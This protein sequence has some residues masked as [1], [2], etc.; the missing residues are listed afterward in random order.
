MRKRV[1]SLL[2]AICLVV[3]LL[4]PTVILAEPAAATESVTIK[5]N[6]AAISVTVEPGNVYYAKAANGTPYDSGFGLNTPGDGSWTMKLDNTKAPAE[7]TLKNGGILLNN[8]LALEISGN[9]ALKIIVEG[10][11]K[12]Q[13]KNRQTT[14]FAM[15]GGTTITSVDNS[16]L[17]FVNTGTSAY[18]A[19]GVSAGSL[20]LDNANVYASNNAHATNSTIMSAIYAKDL[21]VTVKGGNLEV[22]SKN[23]GAL[24]ITAGNL[25][26]QDNAVVTATSTGGSLSNV[27]VEAHQNA[28]VGIR[29]SG[30]FAV[31]N[32]TLKV[33]NQSGAWKY[34]LSK[35]PVIT[36]AIAKYSTSA[37][38]TDL[39]DLDTTSTD[40]VAHPYVE[41]AFACTSHTGGTA[42]CQA[43]AICGLCGAAYGPLADHTYDNDTDTDC[44]VCAA[45][46]PVAAAITATIGG[47]EVNAAIGEIWYAT[48][49]EGNVSDFTKEEI[50]NW[51][52]KLDNTKVPAEL[53]LKS[54]IISNALSTIAGS[55]LKII[56]DGNSEIIRKN[57]SVLTISMPGGT[58]I[59]SVGESLLKIHCGSTSG[60]HALKVDSG[61]L[62][63]DHAYTDF[64]TNTNRADT[65]VRYGIEAPGQTVS[66]IGGAVN[67]S[68]TN[69][70]A[71]AAGA[72]LAGNLIISQ[73]AVVDAWNDATI[74]TAL[75]DGVADN[76]YAINVSGDFIIDHASLTVANLNTNQDIWKHTLSK[77]PTVL[78]ATAQY[79]ESATDIALKDLTLAAGTKVAY[80]Y[81]VFTA[82]P[83]ALRY[84]NLSLDGSIGLNLYF[85]LSDFYFENSYR[86]AYQVGAED[87]REIALDKGALEQDTDGTWIIP[88]SVSAKQMNDQVKFWLVDAKGNAMYTKQ[89]SVTEYAYRIMEMTDEEVRE[90]GYGSNDIDYLKNLIAAMLNYGAKAQQ[91]FGY[92]T[93][94]LADYAL[95]SD[96][97]DAFAAITDEAFMSNNSWN[98]TQGDFF[99]SVTQ[100]EGIESVSVGLDGTTSINVYF[101]LAK[102]DS[103]ENYKFKVTHTEKYDNQLYYNLSDYAYAVADSGDA[104]YNTYY[105]S[106]VGIPAAYLDLT[107]RLE[108]TRDGEKVAALETMVTT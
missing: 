75:N 54:A 14:K 13:S 22:E 49:A 16:K 37:A 46:R 78:G 45:V 90:L 104:D 50:A 32:S 97:S 108:V 31:S 66:I 73:G 7:L 18:A 96:W 35:I 106:I 67:Y 27:P 5:M 65:S 17:S 70:G 82:E 89:T 44:N 83:Y 105:V 60:Y 101:K 52:I 93:D 81:L 39:L 23:N 1:L 41:F 68:T 26:I 36:N 29:V 12:I 103:I 51:N 3:G 95:S 77:M 84:T 99:T 28:R 92:N 53:T 9:G 8:A 11:F 56:V 98:V 42:T 10:D 63:L 58:T 79:S 87:V 4:P 30:N 57:G 25:T 74:T 64:V 94:S 34:T 6:N 59:T 20:T 85:E 48:A 24:A 71:R 62:T 43:Q 21:D 72:I 2:L 15:A 19:L 33:I 55:G 76:R 80:P 61:S 40:P 107:Y 100:G 47:K 102:T 88:I 69:S 91:Y 86:L 38:G